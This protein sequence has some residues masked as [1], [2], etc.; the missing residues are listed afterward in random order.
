MKL[1]RL[2]VMHRALTAGRREA[3][4]VLPAG[5]RYDHISCGCIIKTT[6]SIRCPP[7]HTAHCYCS[8]GCP[9][10]GE[11]AYCDCIPD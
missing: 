8:G 1:P 5:R 9:F 4:G 7:G 3:V 10:P 2:T 11:Y 6:E